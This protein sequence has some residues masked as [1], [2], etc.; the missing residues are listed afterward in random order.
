MR[1]GQV[2]ELEDEMNRLSKIANA[3]P[4]VHG[5][6]GMAMK[7]YQDLKKAIEG[8]RPKPIEDP[9]RADD[10]HRLRKEVEQE[11]IRPTMLTREEMRRN[12]A[13][14][15]DRYLKGE[16]SKEIKQAILTAKRARLAENPDAVDEPN[17][18]NLETIRPSGTP[19]GTSTFM[20]GAQIPGHFAMTP[21]AKANWPAEM[22]PQGTAQSP[23]TMAEAAELLDKPK[24]S[25]AV[26]RKLMS[27]AERAAWGAKM[28]AARRAKQA[29]KVAVE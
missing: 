2:R 29:A 9:R 17:I 24:N 25:G 19:E 23:L 20:P 28:V 6:R 27:E 18:A 11:V 5:N 14:A 13:G 7:R 21:K 4:Y 1:P 26:H 16:A 8:Q 12:P 15:V 22:P 10:I 3:P